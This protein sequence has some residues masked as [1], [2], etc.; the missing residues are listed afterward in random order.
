MVKKLCESVGVECN[1]DS[2]FNL[3][4]SVADFVLS[5]TVTEIK[6]A[7]YGKT[8]K[9]KELRTGTVRRLL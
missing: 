3:L 8:K 7:D 6:Q 5:Q 1:E 4:G 9:D 2:Y